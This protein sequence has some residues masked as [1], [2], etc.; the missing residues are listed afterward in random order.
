MVQIDNYENIY[1]LHYELDGY[2]KEH[3]NSWNYNA[4]ISTFTG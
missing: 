2:F 4:Y 3:G 1:Y